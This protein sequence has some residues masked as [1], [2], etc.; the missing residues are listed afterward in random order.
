MMSNYATARRNMVESQ[1][2]PNGVTDQRIARAMLAVP[3]E[4][5]VPASMRGLAY[6]DQEVLVRPAGRDAP[7]RTLM[8]PMTLARLI[9]LAAVQDDQ[10]VLD[11][12]CATGYSTAILARLAEAV[13]G[14]EQEP[15]LGEA[16][17]RTLTELGADNAAIVS[18][19]HAE[20][21]G[22]EGPYDAILLGGSVPEV[23][24]PLFQQLKNGGR[25]VAILGEGGLGTATLFENVHGD[26]GRRPVFDA[27]A[28]PLTGFERKAAFAF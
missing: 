27:G 5:F 13:V 15:A 24:Q 21:Y 19:A 23:P 14:V 8:A 26:I 6:M 12:G 11:I 20:G 17:S 16:A 2:R 18:G 9:Q 25:L 7:A 28:S 4:L 22:Q 1:V 10:V 3:R